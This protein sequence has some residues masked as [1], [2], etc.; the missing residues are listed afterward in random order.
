MPQT[1]IWKQSAAERRAAF[2][3]VFAKMKPAEQLGPS[4]KTQLRAVHSNIIS[5]RAEGYTVE[6]ICDGMKDPLIGIDVTPG[7]VRKILHAAAVK[8]EKRR[9]ARLAAIVAAAERKPTPV[10]PAV[11]PARPMGTQP[12]TKL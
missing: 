9:K 11:T 2:D 10:T 5:K 8:R 6:Q 7:Y 1:P 3:T 12:G 4:A